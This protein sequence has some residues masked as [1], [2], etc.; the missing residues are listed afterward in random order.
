[1]LG[2]VGWG[3]GDQNFSGAWDPHEI[4]W[5]LLPGCLGPRYG[6]FCAPMPRSLPPPESNFQAAPGWIET[7]AGHPPPPVPHP[8]GPSIPDVMG[9]VG[10]SPG[11][12][13]GHLAGCH[14]GRHKLATAGSSWCWAA[15]GGEPPNF[16][17]S[18]PTCPAGSPICPSRPWA[19]S[20]R[21]AGWGRPCCRA[22]PL[23]MFREQG[24]SSQSSLSWQ[25]DCAFQVLAKP[26][27]VASTSPLAVLKSSPSRPLKFPQRPE[28]PGQGWEGSGASRP[29][30]GPLL[31]QSRWG[32]LPC[33]CPWEA[34]SSVRKSCMTG[35]SCTCSRRP[36]A[37]LTMM[38]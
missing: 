5:A 11:P 17:P 15:P 26:A 9:Q 21:Q 14:H 29:P 8:Q 24:S 27:P 25:L 23:S 30:R 19:G 13:P 12:L 16:C 31:G 1:M 38:W 22:S 36:L 37:V 34:W 33:T 2:I 18:P 4:P 10:T 20:P 7:R 32:H 28:G 6:S 35:A 3:V